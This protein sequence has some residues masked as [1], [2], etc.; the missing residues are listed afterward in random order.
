[1]YLL[2]DVLHGSKDDKPPSDKTTFHLNRMYIHSQNV[3]VKQL[4][5]KSQTSQLDKEDSLH[6]KSIL[7][8][9][10]FEHAKM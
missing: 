10:P 8:L 1:M 6:Q 2:K 5:T 3:W 4:N 7:Q 9:M